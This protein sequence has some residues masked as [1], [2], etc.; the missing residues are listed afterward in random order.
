VLTTSCRAWTARI[1][2]SPS[3]HD[4]SMSYRSCTAAVD[5]TA[6]RTPNVE[7][8]RTRRSCAFFAESKAACQ[9]YR[10]ATS[11][12]QPG[13]GRKRTKGSKRP[14]C[15]CFSCS[16]SRPRLPGEL[17]DKTQRIILITRMCSPGYPHIFLSLL[18]IYVAPSLNVLHILRALGSTSRS[19]AMPCA[20]ACPNSNSLCC[21]FPASMEA[22]GRLY[23]DKPP[24]VP[25]SPY[26]VDAR[27]SFGVC[28]SRPAAGPRAPAVLVAQCSPRR[29]IALWYK[30]SRYNPWLAIPRR[31]QSLPYHASSYLET[32]SRR[33]LRRPPL[34]QE[35]ARYYHLYPERGQKAD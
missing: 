26:T 23:S 21:A 5:E 27:A 2:T 31:P 34:I 35:V 7:R 24:C 3:R 32:R 14:P 19:P 9:I 15:C 33:R 28:R 30:T 13:F 20:P 17:S 8:R 4:F 22:P 25:R 16:P 1:D 10:I 12:L 29:L 11:T 6:N 18:A